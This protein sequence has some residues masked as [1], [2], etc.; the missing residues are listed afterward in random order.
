MI[1][2]SITELF[3]NEIV[4]FPRLMRSQLRQ[5]LVVLFSEPQ[6][7]T[8]VAV[9]EDEPIYFIGDHSTDWDQTQ[10]NLFMGDIRLFNDDADAYVDSDAEGMGAAQADVDEEVRA[11]VARIF[12]FMG[13]LPSFAGQLGAVPASVNIMSEAIE[14][15]AKRR[16][17]ERSPEAANNFSKSFSEFVAQAD[18]TAAAADQ[19]GA[20]ANDEGTESDGVRHVFVF[21]GG[22]DGQPPE[23]LKKILEM[24][25]SSGAVF[26]GAS[27]EAGQESKRG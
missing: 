19:F 26:G 15:M 4:P 11:E 14:K 8:V 12:D 5:T 17:T 20:S 1:S 18:T 7:G 25:I 3:A 27:N 6:V 9:G 10:F 23:A 22:D 16:T 24:L 13:G 21:G 2:S